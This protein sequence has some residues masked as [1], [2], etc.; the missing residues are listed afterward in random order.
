MGRAWSLVGLAPRQLAVDI[1]SSLHSHPAGR[2]LR[3]SSPDESDASA[4]VP[5]HVTGPA[6]R[7]GPNVAGTR[8]PPTRAGPYPHPRADPAVQMGFRCA[9]P[10]GAGFDP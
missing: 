10:P 9:L 4:G 5:R 2:S 1:V 7:L 6:P 3:I 8:V